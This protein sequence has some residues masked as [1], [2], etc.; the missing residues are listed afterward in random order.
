NSKNHIDMKQLF[1]SAVF[2][3][4]VSVSFGQAFKDV[5]PPPAAPASK[6]VMTFEDGNNDTSLDYG[7]I[8]QKSDPLRRV[9]FTNTGTEPLVIKNARGSCGCTVPDWP[10]EPILPGETG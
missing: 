6:A 9:K 7:K 10:K 2:A 4:F 8:S 5:P 1:F 3:L